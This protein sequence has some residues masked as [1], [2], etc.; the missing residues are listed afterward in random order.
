MFDEKNFQVI[1]R[2]VKNEQPKLNSQKTFF[3]L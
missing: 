3:R 2:L 1:D